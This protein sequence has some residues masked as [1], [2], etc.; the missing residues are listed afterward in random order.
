MK[1]ERRWRERKQLRDAALINHMRAK[2]GA[3]VITAGSGL[4]GVGVSSSSATASS[5]GPFDSSSSLVP[6]SEQAMTPFAN[7]T[8]RGSSAS[9]IAA[10]SRAQTSHSRHSRASSVGAGRPM[11]HREW[12]KTQKPN[13]FL[14]NRVV[15]DR[16]AKHEDPA[17]AAARQKRESTTAAFNPKDQ[18]FQDVLDACWPEV[19]T[20]SSSA[21]EALKRL[22]RPRGGSS[23][24]GGG[25]GKHLRRPLR[26]QG[27]ESRTKKE[28]KQ[29]GQS[30]SFP[31]DDVVNSHG[32]T[33][34]GQAVV[35]N[36]EG[37]I[38]FLVEMKADLGFHDT[39]GA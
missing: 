8:S 14:Q 35:D 24:S 34:L 31:V 33:L 32:Y 3:P 38:D 17:E 19:A 10:V 20:K 22:L 23:R 11:S 25:G 36:N 18:P 21:V 16:F 6:S 5:F 26:L 15:V 30:V 27:I 37:A 4:P 12:K 39:N 28:E 13:K 9:S 29:G 2:R 1:R 7:E